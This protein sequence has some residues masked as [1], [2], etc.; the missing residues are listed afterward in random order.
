MTLLARGCVAGVAAL[1]LATACVSTAKLP[2]D[3]PPGLAAART[4]IDQAYDAGAAATTPRT[5][6]RAE[7]KL[8]AAL[9][10]YRDDP[11]A[12]SAAANAV[13]EDALLA[14]ELHRSVH[15]WDE[16]IAAYAVLR[17]N[18]TD[19]GILRKQLRERPRRRDVDV[20]G[21]FELSK[22]LAFFAPGDA[23]VAG[24]DRGAVAELAA[25]LKTQPDLEVELVGYGDPR[26]PA[27][28][29]EELGKR[30]ADAVAASMAAA[31]VAAERIRINF[32]PRAA[33]ESPRRAAVARR[34][35]AFI[36]A[37]AH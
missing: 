36:T 7:A 16:D 34:V 9:S 11:A 13:R 30:R 28:R 3:A 18:A 10:S 19:T 1:A 26:Q 4:A 6:A 14:L 32:K 29:A 37:P 15:E 20:S 24:A 12:A 17:R 21:G 27:V 23:E 22:P 8:N 2:P 35:D 33:G 31:G 25:L 5:L